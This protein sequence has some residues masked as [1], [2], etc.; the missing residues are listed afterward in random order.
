[1]FGIFAADNSVVSYILER[2]NRHVKTIAPDADANYEKIFQIDATNLEPQVALPHSLA[3][4]K[5]VNSIGHIR[6]DQAMLRGVLSKISDLGLTLV[7]VQQ[8]E[9]DN[10]G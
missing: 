1:M 8:Q 10:T 5:H 3:N 9:P 6:I 2:Q 4:S 7:S